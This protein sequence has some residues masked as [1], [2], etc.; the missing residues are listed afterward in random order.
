MRHVCGGSGSLGWNRGCRGW[1]RCCSSCSGGWVRLFGPRSLGSSDISDGRHAWL[2][3]SRHGGWDDI[4]GRGLRILGGG[5]SR[6]SLLGIVVVVVV[7]A[8]VVARS[9][10][11]ARATASTT[12]VTASPPSFAAT[13]TFAA[14]TSFAA[15]FSSASSTALVSTT[16][17]SRFAFGVGC[18]CGRCRRFTIAFVN[19]FPFRF[20][21]THGFFPPQTNLGTD[22][23]FVAFEGSN[24]FVEFTL[25]VRRTRLPKL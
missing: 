15:S 22:F 10:S 24:Q 17:E 18:R 12:A 1:D 16:A 21:W 13:T 8:L 20:G 3:R 25:F 6:R 2:G 19:I 23:G 11:S 9:V 4:G 7:R 14:S 5:L